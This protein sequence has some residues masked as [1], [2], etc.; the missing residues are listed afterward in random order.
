MMEIEKTNHDET[1]SMPHYHIYH[2][3][4]EE[5]CYAENRDWNTIYRGA[6]SLI[7]LYSLPVSFWISLYEI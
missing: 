1:S 3:Q 6:G 2:Q 5:P 7:I 4:Q